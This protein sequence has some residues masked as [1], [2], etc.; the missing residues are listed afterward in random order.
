M[1][2]LEG[3]ARRFAAEAHGRVG[4]VRKYTGEPYIVHPAAVVE[5]VRTV[6]HTEAMLAAAW[7]HDT[8]ED[9]DVGPD[10]IQS[11][12]GA[13]VAALVSWL[14]D[15][16]R[17]EDG[18]RA[19]RKAIDRDHLARAP[20]SAQTIKLADLIDNSRSI[21]LCDPKFVKVYLPEKRALLSVLGRGAPT[22]FV[23]AETITAEFE[24]ARAPMPY[25]IRRPGAG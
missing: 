5:L 25:G 14:T 3:R 8:V 2:D 21:M 13:E 16:S 20:G 12:F 6:P 10:D 7:L 23:L 22:L 1:M 17:P 19:T 9:T 4:Q 18:N 11:E 15:V 24:A